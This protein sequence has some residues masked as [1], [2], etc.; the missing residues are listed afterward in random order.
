MS[1]AYRGPAGTEA[2]I[3]YVTTRLAQAPDIFY[4]HGSINAEMEAWILVHGLLEQKVVDSIDV[5]FDEDRG[6]ALEPDM[7]NF[8]GW[9]G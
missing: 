7:E 9:N 3:Q 1:D 8:P 4:G 6:L 5:H 2:L